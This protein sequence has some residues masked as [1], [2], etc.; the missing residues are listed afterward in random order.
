MDEG[1]NGVQVLIQ[2]LDPD[3]PLPHYAHPGDAGADLV[4]AEEVTLLPGGRTL[5][6]TGVALALPEGLVAFVMPRSGLAAM[7]GVTTLNAP[8][9]IDSGYRGEIRVNL[10]NHG[11]E[12]VRLRRGDRI[13][14]LVIQR[15]EHAIFTV[16]E[17]LPTS[18]RGTSGHGSTGGHAGLAR[19]GGE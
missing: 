5:V 7:F 6:G 14:Q 19:P 13:A 15:V 3:L 12:P 11:S 17:Q 4:A 18:S 9:T 1:A 10:V 16:S 8:G 2:Q